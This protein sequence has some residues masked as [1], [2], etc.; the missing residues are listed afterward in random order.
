[1][2]DR[3]VN[4]LLTQ[5]DGVEGLEGVYV[6]AATSRPDLIDPALLRPGRLDKCLQCQLPNM[7][8]RLKIFEAL[9]KKMS[10][11]KTVD[12]EY[13]ARKCEHF[14]GA[15]IKALLYN[16]QLESIHEFTGK[17][18]KGEDSGFPMF[19]N[20]GMRQQS[21]KSRRSRS[22]KLL[23]VETVPPKVS[24]NKKIAHIPKLKDGPSPVMEEMEEKLSSQVEQ[25][26][27]RLRV[28]K[29]TEHVSTVDSMFSPVTT[30]KGQLIQINQ[31]HL[32]A[33]LKKTHP[34]VTEKERMK[35]KRIYENFTSTRGGDFGTSVE[36]TVGSRQTL[37]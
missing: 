12:L 33:A 20:D 31:S 6:L 15:D 25:I 2:T 21:A 9:T 10:L 16:A 22:Q 13:F 19:S 1:M 35:F 7:E 29:A 3:V 14:S 32:L 8:E 5:L 4:Q 27:G 18:L 23:R 34:S 30:C 36:Q 26:R 11:G 17:V 37:A 24:T 28:N